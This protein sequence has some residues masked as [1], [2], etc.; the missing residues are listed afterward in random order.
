MKLIKKYFFISIMALMLVLACSCQTKT[1]KLEKPTNLSYDDNYVLTWDSVENATGYTV[2][3]GTKSF[4]VTT[5]VA[6]LTTYLSEGNNNVWVTATSTDKKFTTS[7][8]ASIVVNY[9]PFTATTLIDGLT[10]QYKAALV[11]QKTNFETE[12]AYNEYC[13]GV[14][15]AAAVEFEAACK[16]VSVTTDQVLAINQFTIMMNQETAPTMETVFAT[17]D[18]IRDSKISYNSLAKM[19]FNVIAAQASAPLADMPT[20]G[21][22]AMGMEA[23][24]G[25]FATNETL[26]VDTFSVIYE[27]ID[28]SFAD[29]EV[30]YTKFA[31]SEQT[32]EDSH[33]LFVAAVNAFL[34]ENRPRIEKFATLTAFI[35][36]YINMMMTAPDVT[37]EA[38]IIP[39]V[40]TFALAVIDP[41]LDIIA[42]TATVISAADMETIVNCGMEIYAAITTIMPQPGVK[43]AEPAP[44]EPTTPT[45]PTPEEIAAVVTTI[46][47][48]VETIMTTISAAAQ[49]VDL[50]AEMEKIN[51]ALNT[52]VNSQSV[53]DLV[54]SYIAMFIST[55]MPEKTEEEVAQIVANIRTVVANF[56]PQTGTV[57]TLV[58]DI[59]AAMG[60]TSEEAKAIVVEMVSTMI[61]Q[62]I[63]TPEEALEMASM[64][65]QVITVIDE[66]KDPTTGEIKVA[67]IIAL[68]PADY[69]PIVDAILPENFDRN[70]LI[71]A[72]YVELV[73]EIINA[74]IVKANETVEMLSDHIQPQYIG[75]WIISSDVEFPAVSMIEITEHS[76]YF[77]GERAMN[78]VYAGN[79]YY[80]YTIN[81]MGMEYYVVI[82]GAGTETERIVVGNA[83]DETQLE[84]TKVQEVGP[85]TEIT[86]PE[87]YIGTFTGT[88]EET[89]DTYTI[90]ITAETITINDVICEITAYD[91]YQ[92][93]TV[94][95]NG[96]ECYVMPGYESGQIMF[97]NTVSSVYVTLTIATDTPTP[98]PTPT[99]PANFVGTYSGSL[100]DGNTYT[101]VITETAITI[102]DV[103]FVITGE[104]DGSLVG[105]INDVEFSISFSYG[106]GVIFIANS[107]YSIYGQISLAA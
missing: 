17:I 22:P 4:D 37:P 50:T 1:T 33:A 32:V 71:P 77:D 59:I 100:N 82:M 16:G 79:D 62:N 30:A 43:P 23:I 61:T 73:V 78:V 24:I 52:L 55:I 27:Y 75:T 48:N 76:I 74:T 3:V 26:T 7:D 69:A 44:T 5:N 41:T 80:G 29:F 98:T 64:L 89:A 13:A 63:M 46:K 81:V 94:T 14:A 106:D 47:T 49:K 91:E 35:N 20:T 65:E 57:E 34:G 88:V 103:E 93:F 42:K 28:K 10:E 2:L 99:I 104:V 39:D 18:G 31:A 85:G 67:D 9:N 97:Y 95:L 72:N 105:T 101:V 107:D 15:K 84:F 92:G 56:D 51:T 87:T 53:Q 12:E 70:T 58:Q 86:I 38:K 11:S 90:V 102:N 8:G 19:T 60:L 68:I 96:E 54:N 83:M 36:Q 21:D 45:T 40:F 66:L 6:D 25:I